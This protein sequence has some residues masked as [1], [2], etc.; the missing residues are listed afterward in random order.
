M[1]LQNI[2]SLL[3][4]ICPLGPQLFLGILE[5]SVFLELPK[6]LGA[7]HGRLV[8]SVPDFFIL[9]SHHMVYKYRSMSKKSLWKLK[10]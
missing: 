4:E 3:P 10:K 8:L 5:P 1:R 7:W 6:L 2:S 9:N